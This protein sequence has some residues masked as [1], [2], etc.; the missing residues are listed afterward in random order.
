MIDFWGQV[1]GTTGFKEFFFGVKAK[2][3]E[4]GNEA[5]PNGPTPNDDHQQEGTFGSR[6]PHQRSADAIQ[7]GYLTDRYR[8]T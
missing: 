8:V 2:K 5:L 4:T 1:P 7:G 3:S 6:Q